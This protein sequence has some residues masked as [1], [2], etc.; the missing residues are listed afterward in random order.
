MKV[1]LPSDARRGFRIKRLV[2]GAVAYYWECPEKE[3][4]AKLAISQPIG[5]RPDGTHDLGL[6]IQDA[7]R[8]NREINERRGTPPSG[9]TPGTLRWIFLWYEKSRFFRG[10][11]SETQEAYRRRMAT[12]LDFPVKKLRLADIPVRSILPKHAD[13]IWEWFNDQGK[14]QTANLTCRIARS[15]WN[16]AIREGKSYPDST[17]W[18]VVNPFEKM[19]L[20]T[21]RTVTRIW[22]IGEVY[23]FI[24]AADDDGTPI[25]GTAALMAYEWCQRRI[26]IRTTITW[27]GYDG[28]KIGFVQSKTGEPVAIPMYDDDGVPLFPELQERLSKTPRHGPLIVMRHDKRT[29]VYRPYTDSEFS[30]TFR[31]LADAAGLPKELQ[32]RALRHTGTTEVLDGGATDQEAMNLSGHE[33]VSML[34]VYGKKTL[35][36]AGNAARKRRDARTK[37][38]GNS[39]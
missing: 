13:T 31:R 3:R 33:S 15:I 18:P 12:L 30:K 4:A 29:G 21:V 14:V 5:L 22:T 39:E 27:S 11:R 2:N 32:F 37:K 28:Q 16:R 36:Q 24:Q 26:D 19:K 38:H 23:G 7:Q 8:L 25:M 10:L 9:P 1:D 20:P 17:H 34:R 35:R 6:A